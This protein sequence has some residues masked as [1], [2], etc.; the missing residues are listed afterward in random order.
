[1]LEGKNFNMYNPSVPKYKKNGSK[2]VDVFGAKFGPRMT[3]VI[4][5]T[6]NS[7]LRAQVS[8]IQLFSLV[9]KVHNFS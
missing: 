5:N 4:I 1:M 8:S 7:S 2:K 9:D 6:F 3:F